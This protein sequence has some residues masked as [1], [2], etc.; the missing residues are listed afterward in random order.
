[1]SLRLLMSLAVIGF[2]FTLAL[3]LFF[4]VLA[5]FAIGLLIAALIDPPVDWLEKKWRW[6]R[7]AASLILLSAFVVGLIGLFVLAASSVYRECHS[8]LE[9]LPQISR[10]GAGFMLYLGQIFARLQRLVPPEVQKGFSALIENGFTALTGLVFGVVKSLET[11]P[12]ALGASML[13]VVSAFFFSRDKALL[14]AAALRCLPAKWQALAHGVCRELFLAV[15]DR[16]RL[17][18]AMMACTFLLVG[19]VLSTIAQPRAWSIGLLAGI[20]ELIPLVGP[21]ALLLPW[22][23]WLLVTDGP[24]L[25]LLFVML[26]LAVGFIRQWAEIRFIGS[27]LGLHPLAVLLGM[28]VGLKFYGL[29]GLIGGPLF[30]ATLRTSYVYLQ[31][32]AAMSSLKPGKSTTRAG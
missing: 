3:K 27:G 11:L 30:L 5:P 18:L 10:Q 2:L 1:M 28:A 17:E 19:G 21:G 24:N 32:E 4:P 9:Q 31:K 22:A 12:R 16:I 6:S 26:A 14:Q 29:P 7:S 8:L 23:G 13:A 25:A 20:L 15:L